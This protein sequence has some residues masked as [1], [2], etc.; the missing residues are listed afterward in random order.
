MK[1]KTMATGSSS[2][3]MCCAL[4]NALPAAALLVMSRE[5]TVVSRVAV[6]VWHRPALPRLR[7][8]IEMKCCH[9]LETMQTV[10][11]GCSTGR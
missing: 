9:Q 4:V 10:R 8:Q 3:E 5:R 7:V 1:L 6:F 11:R 2:D